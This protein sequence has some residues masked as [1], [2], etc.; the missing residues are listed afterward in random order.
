VTVVDL[1]LDV[2][3]LRNGEVRLLDQDEF[4]QHQVEFAYPRTLV[5]LASRQAVDVLESVTIGSE[6]FGGHRAAQWQKKISSP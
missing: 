4:R 1:D 3:R 6:P 2:V 5:A